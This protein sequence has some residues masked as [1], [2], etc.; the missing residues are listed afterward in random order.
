M[1]NLQRLNSKIVDRKLLTEIVERIK[2]CDKKIVFTN[3]CFDILHAG[4]VRYLKAARQ[5]GNI[6]VV[7]VNS[8]DSIKRLKGHT[9]PIQ[10]LADRLEVLAGLAC[11]DFVISFHED[12]PINLIRQV[13]PDFLVKGSDYAPEKIVGYEELMSWGGKV[14]VI[15]LYEGRSTSRI[16]SQVKAMSFN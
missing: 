15:P 4:H 16:V 11:V 5:M 1:T 14:A 12:T 7:A 13:K 9:R 2:S 8:D 3:G 6:L 10:T